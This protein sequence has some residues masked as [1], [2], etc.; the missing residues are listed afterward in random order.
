MSD[1]L[2]FRV[3]EKIRVKIQNR[4]FYKL[5][6]SLVKEQTEPCLVN[7]HIKRTE[8]IV[9]ITREDIKSSMFLRNNSSD[10]LVYKDVI[11]SKEYE[12]TATKEPRTIIDAGANIG[13]TS[14]FFAN[15]YPNAK[16]IAIEPDESNIKIL[17]MNI[18]PYKN[19]HLIKGALWDSVGEIDLLDAGLGNWGFMVGNEKDTNG[20]KLPATSKYKTKTITIEKICELYELDEIDILKIDIEGSEKEVFNNSSQWINKVNLIVVELHERMKKGCDKAFYGIRK[21][22]DKCCKNHEDIYLIKNDYIKSTS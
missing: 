16:I 12:F 19:I 7:T 14:V 22:F 2:F 10:V 4:F 3:L 21:Y 1:T 11:D 13:L 20:I 18:K 8:D 9:E 17:E 15:K 5:N 6:C